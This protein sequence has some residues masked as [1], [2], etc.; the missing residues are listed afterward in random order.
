MSTSLVTSTF[1]ISNSLPATENEAG[2]EAL[3]W[4]QV[5]G[6]G[7]AGAP[8]F[9]HS[10]I[11]VPDLESGITRAVKG[12]KAG[13]DTD[14]NFR[15]IASDAGQALVDTCDQSTTDCSVKW[16]HPTAANKTTYAQGVIHSLSMNEFDGENYAGSVF[17][18]RPNTR[19]MTFAT[20]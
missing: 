11:D 20:T 17:K 4:T 2:Y 16:V 5:K 15:F 18:F 19:P 9:A 14:L 6:I 7:M 10:L 8:K 12:M 1:W 3:T 13:E